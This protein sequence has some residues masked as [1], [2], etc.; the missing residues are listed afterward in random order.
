MG[1]THLRPLGRNVPHAA[2]KVELS[3]AC[4][5]QFAGTTGEQRHEL[6]RRLRCWLTDEAFN[7]PQQ[8][9]E[10]RWIGYRSTVL[11]LWRGDCSAQGVC[12]IVVGASGGDSVA[13]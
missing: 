5:P 1:S 10:L 3:P 12:R 13:E 2:V 8:P 4:V 7:S 11:L 9:T 6:Q